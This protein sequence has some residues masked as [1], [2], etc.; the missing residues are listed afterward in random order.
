MIGDLIIQH[1]SPTC[2]VYYLEPPLS[3][4]YCFPAELL[5]AAYS[6]H[7]IIGDYMTAVLRWFEGGSKENIQVGLFRGWGYLMC[8]FI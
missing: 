4:S 3:V 7:E 5:G 2:T 1:P 6:S 8:R